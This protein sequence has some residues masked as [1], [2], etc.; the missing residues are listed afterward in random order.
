MARAWGIFWTPCIKIL[1]V[2]AVTVKVMEMEMETEKVSRILIR[3]RSQTI[4]NLV[5]VNEK[6]KLQLTNTQVMED[7]HFMNP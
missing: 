6:R 1:T 2:T 3:N 4:V 7:F 5:V